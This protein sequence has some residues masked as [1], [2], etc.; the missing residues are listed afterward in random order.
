MRNYRRSSFLR[1][2]KAEGCQA[3]ESLLIARDVLQYFRP[4]QA[5]ANGGVAGPRGKTCG[6]GVVW[7]IALPMHAGSPF[8]TLLG[9]N[10][11]RAVLTI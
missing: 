6:E 3:K 5:G 2:R 11:E 10:T 8:A 9:Q 4:R 1:S 7:G